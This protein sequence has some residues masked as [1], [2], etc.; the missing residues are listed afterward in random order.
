MIEKLYFDR[1]LSVFHYDGIIKNLIHEF[2][3]KNRLSLSNDFTELAAGFIK[4]HAIGKE[5][6]I[7]LS[8]PMHPLK[9]FK[10]EINASDV[11]ARKI[12]K[13]LNCRHS[14]KV[15]KKTR[16]T[17]SQSRLSRRERIENVKQSFS[18]NNNKKSEIKNKNILLVDDLFTSGNTVN[19]CAKALK[20]ASSGH[21]EVLTLA[22]GDRLT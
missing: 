15:L 4:E 13:I 11:L 17:A 21:I 18:V 14:A 22:R 12:A 6:D 8:I 2:K 7:V 5:A 3:Y 1:A 10:R 16:N 19:E 9:L 20:K